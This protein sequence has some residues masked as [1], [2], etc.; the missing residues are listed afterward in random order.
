MADSE[1]TTMR[2]LDELVARVGDGE[3]N[4]AATE[5]LRKLVDALQERAGEEGTAKGELSLN[6]RFKARGNGKVEISYTCKTKVPQRPTHAT[7]AWIGRKGGLSTQDE[8]QA[9]LP[10]GGGPNV[11]SIHGEKKGNGN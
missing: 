5:Q 10:I 4:T 11:T 6:V 8:R 9:R 1:Q 2:S 7:E 3:L